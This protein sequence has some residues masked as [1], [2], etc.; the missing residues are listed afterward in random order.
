MLLNSTPTVHSLYILEKL[1]IQVDD[2]YVLQVLQYDIK[3]INH[4]LFC[5][6]FL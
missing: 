4:Q 3:Q 2:L 6:Q 5:I 1:K